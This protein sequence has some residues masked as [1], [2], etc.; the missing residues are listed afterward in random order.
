MISFGSKNRRRDVAP[1]R[2][3]ARDP[4][5]SNLDE[6]TRFRRNKTLSGVH[7]SDDTVQPSERAKAH[8]LAKQRR[9]VGG[10]LLLVLGV[11]IILG[12]LLTQFTARVVV[13]G[14]SEPL[15]QTVEGTEYEAAINDYL[16]LN[17]VERFRFVMNDAEL[18]RHVS[19]ITPEVAKVELSST[20][21]LVESHFTITF[22]RPV[23]GWQI[24]GRQYYVDRE[25]VVFEKNYYDA[26]A[27]QIVDESGA[28]PQQGA[29]VA[30]TR[31]LSFVGQVVALSREGGYSVNRAVLP[32]GSTRQVEIKL[33]GVRPYI[34]LTIDRVAGEQV[35]DMIK[36]LDYLKAHRIQAEY[37][38]VRVSGRAVYR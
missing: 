19:L 17:P 29:T 34:K 18:S 28:S 2:A 15:T 3:Q 31:L 35:S 1:R 16:G 12:V 4:R 22:R 13:A 7:H 23:A 38:D 21:N 32:I 36:V 30:S 20:S 25:G 9:K 6:E 14:S 10:I 27:V 8:R 33:K 37:I 24:N 5:Q 26:P 11:I